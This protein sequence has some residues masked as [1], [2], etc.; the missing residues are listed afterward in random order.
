[1]APQTANAR[2]STTE[3]KTTK[4]VEQVAVYAYSLP[5]QTAVLAFD[6]SYDDLFF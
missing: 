2:R 6:L 1:M 3:N 4:D 5:S